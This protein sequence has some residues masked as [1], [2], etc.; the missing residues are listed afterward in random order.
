MGGD[1]DG[2]TEDETTA[3]LLWRLPELGLELSVDFW[4]LLGVP[5]LDKKLAVSWSCHADG[6]VI[7]VTVVALS[8]WLE[9]TERCLCT[10]RRDGTKVGADD[11]SVL[12]GEAGQIGDWGAIVDLL[13]VSERSDMGLSAL[14]WYQKG[15]E[16]RTQT[17]AKKDGRLGY[18]NKNK[19]KKP[20]IMS[21]GHFYLFLIFNK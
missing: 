10:R 9:H 2:D 11:S 13:V 5:A 1:G 21:M 4:V 8:V 19:N 20:K 14:I 7:V 6:S 16:A 18:W 15:M 3:G 12:D 17:E